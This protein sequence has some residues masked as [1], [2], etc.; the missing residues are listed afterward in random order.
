MIGP[1]DWMSEPAYGAGIALCLQPNANEIRLEYDSDFFGAYLRLREAP[2]IGCFAC[3]WIPE[4][5]DAKTRAELIALLFQQVHRAFTETFKAV[6]GKANTFKVKPAL[7]DTALS[8]TRAI[9]REFRGVFSGPGNPIYSWYTLHKAEDVYEYNLRG[10][11][12][13]W[14]GLFHEVS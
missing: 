2:G 6:P 5:H 13:L 14:D 12:R 11:L 8:I 1:L 3:P 9:L 4:T 10:T 7:I